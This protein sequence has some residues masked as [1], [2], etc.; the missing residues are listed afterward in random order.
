MTPLVLA[1]NNGKTHVA[2]V[3]LA[4]AS[5]VDKDA[6][7]KKL[8]EACAKSDWKK[9]KTLLACGAGTDA[10][11]GNGETALFKTIAAG[12]KEAANTM[13][14]LLEKGANAT[15]KNKDGHSLLRIAASKGSLETVKTLVDNKVK[16]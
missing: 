2:K 10:K 11:D 6:L 16:L 4:K 12:N 13:K 5:K 8:L 7:A 1:A 14:L 9:A 3:L 15:E